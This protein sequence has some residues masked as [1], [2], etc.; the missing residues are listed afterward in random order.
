MCK[1]ICCYP[2]RGKQGGAFDPKFCIYVLNKHSFHGLTIWFCVFNLCPMLQLC[3][4]YLHKAVQGWAFLMRL[5]HHISLLYVRVNSILFR[6]IST[7]IGCNLLPIFSC[8]NVHLG[9]HT[10]AGL[11]T[12]AVLDDVMSQNELTTPCFLGTGL[13]MSLY[14][15]TFFQL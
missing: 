8:S 9:R 15:V 1:D 6:Q 11:F 14:L 13:K 3:T 12:C 4:F 10:H 2:I 5:V 7:C